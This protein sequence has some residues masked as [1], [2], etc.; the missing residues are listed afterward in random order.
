MGTVE[1]SLSR[2]RFF[3]RLLLIAGLLLSAALKEP[4]VSP[5][6]G[7]G[8]PAGNPSA[9]STANP[10]PAGIPSSGPTPTAATA[11]ASSHP[12][13]DRMSRRAEAPPAPEA[14]SSAEPAPDAYEVWRR[15]LRLVEQRAYQQM[16]IANALLADRLRSG[17][18]AEIYQEIANLLR[19]ENLLFQVRS[20]LVELLGEI[21]TPEALALLLDLADQGMESPLYAPALNTIS[22]IG[23]NRWGGRF[24]EELSP[25]LE[26]AWKDAGNTDWP[27]L[28]AVT[29]AIVGIGAPSGMGLLL[30]TLAGRDSA[31][32]SSG[33]TRGK[34]VAVFQETPKVT[35]PAA[36]SVLKRAVT[37]TEASSLK[38]SGSTPLE[39]TSTVDPTPVSGTATIESHAPSTQVP[40]E[41]VFTAS[42]ESTDGASA[43]GLGQTAPSGDPSSGAPAQPAVVPV[44]IQGLEN[45]GTETAL[46]AIAEIS[47]SYPE[48]KAL[49]AEPVP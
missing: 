4:P 12:H 41:S 46:N 33:E 22:H 16:P 26:Q 24:H 9:A 3:Q 38:D 36:V 37:G 32:A 11:T 8:S 6:P 49:L 43:A 15:W 25:L 42:S 44:V 27:Y 39:A 13:P 14:S 1:V 10:Q 23:E 31:A 2:R 5:A 30:D 21:A 29:Q 45:I 48:I 17:G 19:D 18:G 47:S 20:Q 35:N 40:A 34:R 28:M 7:R